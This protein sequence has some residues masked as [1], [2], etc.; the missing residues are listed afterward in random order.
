MAQKDTAKN[1]NGGNL[2]FEAD[3]FK[4]ADKLRGNMEPSDYKHVALGLIFLKYISDAFEAKHNALLAEDAQA[5][6]DKDEYLADNVFWVP[7]EARWSHLQANAK[8]PTIGTLIDDAMRAIEK[9]NESLKGVLPKDYSRL[10]LNKV[11]LGE[12]ID[13][14]SGIALNEEGDRSK[15]ILGRV[16]EYFLS[17]FAGA[18][19]KRGGEFYTPRSVVRVLVEMIEPYSGRVYDPCCG[20]G[21]MFVQSEKFVHEH[22]GR[23]GDIAIYGQ[24]SN[25]TTWRLA[26][27]NL[28][29]RGID[30]DIRWNNEGSF[31]KDELRDLKADYILANPPFN[32]SDWGGDR[33]RED[34]RWKFGEPPVGNANYAWLQHIYHHLAPNGK[35][36]VVLANGSMSSSQSSEGDIRKAMLEADAV[37]CMVALPGQLFYSTTNPRLSVVLNP[38]QE[39]W[40]GTM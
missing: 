32:I 37:D 33:L 25:Y 4:A 10:A 38:K 30:S 34:V 2:G 15:D 8:L 29:V 14:I 3:L 12:L 21:G 1:G 23:I 16:Y 26:K 31:H 24:E 6:E 40:Q 36:G 27:M 11:M 22:G 39:P 20:S 18:E 28:A 19:G 7:K 17:Q 35:A 5:A 9:D 13:L